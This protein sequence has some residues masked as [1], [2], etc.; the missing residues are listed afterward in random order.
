MSERAASRRGAAA[1]LL[2]GLVL[3]GIFLL[4]QAAAE[5][6]WSAAE[7]ATLR[8]LWIGRL[9]PL[10]PDPTNAVADSPDAAKLGQR[11]FF[12]PRLSQNSGIS[13]ATCHQPIRRFTDGLPKAVGVGM[14]KRNALSVVASAYSPWLYWDGRRDSLWSQALTPLEDV[15]EHGATREQ[16]VA[17]VVGDSGY[18]AAYRQVFGTEPDATSQDA[19]NRTFA[20]IGK[21]LAAYER[22][23]LPGPSRFDRFVE[24]VVDG[25]EDLQ[26]ELYSSDESAGLKLFIS[27]AECT[28]CHNGPLLTNNEFH[29]TGTLSYPGD[30]PDKGR[31]AGVPQVRADPFNCLGD[32]S[33]GAASDCVELEFVRTGPDLLGAFRTPSLRN[34]EDTEPYMHK[35]QLKT[36]ADV[37]RHYNQAPAAMIGHSE[38]TPLSLGKRELEELEAFLRTLAAPLAT[39][40]EWLEPPPD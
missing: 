3:A 7:V 30:P 17:F 26:R 38:L 28:N 39:S 4:P 36:L 19:V 21:A 31:A 34:L 32:Y 29:N 24:A 9:G 15:D 25:N 27:D 10:P 2:A 35:G 11:L 6:T 14:S 22:L 40:G 18:R 5:E 16:V 12:D 8:S 37:L 23:L 1:C 20:N 13:C 33:D